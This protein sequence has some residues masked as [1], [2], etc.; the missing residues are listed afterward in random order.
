LL[1]QAHAPSFLPLLSFD[2]SAPSS[3]QALEDGCIPSKVVIQLATQVVIPNYSRDFASIPIQDFKPS[4]LAMDDGSLL[5]APLVS[6]VK[7]A[8]LSIIFLSIVLVFFVRNIVVT[9]YYYFSRSKIIHD[10]RLFF[11]L[12]F[13]QLVS[14]AGILP[15]MVSY[16]DAYEDCTTI[17]RFER[18]V[19]F[20]SLSILIYGILGFKAYRVLENSRAVIVVAT[21]LQL[22][23]TGILVLEVAGTE[24][25]RRLSGS[26][27]L[28][29]IP[30]SMLGSVSIQLAQA[31][32]V[33]ICCTSRSSGVLLPRGRL[34]SLL[35]N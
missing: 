2:M 13:S 8:L 31:I 16:L 29:E 21:I 7:A 22:G 32:F 27:T 33:A 17:L 25:H 12:F 10:R 20:F 24:G 11:A 26:C 30:T 14:P 15:T 19:K 4:Y 18:C 3:S 9:G 23:S 6:D 28:D 5:A 1:Q 34:N 35:I